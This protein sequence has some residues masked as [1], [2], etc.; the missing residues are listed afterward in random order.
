MQSLARATA[1]LFLCAC[2]GLP[3]LPPGFTAALAESPTEPPCRLRTAGDRVVAAAVPVGPGG[4]PPAVRT[5]I[6]SIQPG[7]KT[8][9]AGREWG[10]RGDGYRSEKLYT[11][12]GQ[13]HFRSLLVAADGRVLERS[14]SVPLASAPPAVVTAAMASGPE[15]M[16]LEIVSGPEHEEGWRATVRNRAGWTHEVILSLRGTVLQVSRVVAAQFTSG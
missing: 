1:L 5:A 7:G 14:H 13:E 9:F 4:L 12:Q 2:G 10:P 15:V 3:K 11:D 8:L 6:D 16:R